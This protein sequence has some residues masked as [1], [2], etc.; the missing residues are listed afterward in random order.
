[1]KEEEKDKDEQYD[2]EP[3]KLA[4]VIPFRQR[5]DELLEFAPWIH[6][7]LNDQ[8]VK[9]NIYVVNQVDNHRFVP[10]YRLNIL[11]LKEKIIW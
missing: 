11:N 10:C 6:K 1:M 4:V 8:R 3:H 2:W 5:F 9:H 7:F